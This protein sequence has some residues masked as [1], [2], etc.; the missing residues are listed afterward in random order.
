MYATR[1]DMVDRYG[2]RELA[3]LEDVHR[4]GQPDATVTER[5]LSDASDEVDSYLFARYTLPLSGSSPTLVRV[6]CDIARRRLYRDKPLEEVLKRYEEAVDWLK[7]VS[8][9]RAGLTFAATVG[10]PAAATKTPA[11]PAVATSDVGSVFTNTILDTIPT[12]ENTQ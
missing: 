12:L 7:A 9:G 4:T 2:L 5:A 3:A 1:Q 11:L 10:E 6:V 8:A